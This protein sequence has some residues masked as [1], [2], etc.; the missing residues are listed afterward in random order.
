MLRMLLAC[1]LLFGVVPA[2]LLPSFRSRS[3]MERLFAMALFMG[4]LAVLVMHLLVRLRINDNVALVIL[5]LWAI[6]FK[7]WTRWRRSDIGFVLIKSVL[8]RWIEIFSRPSTARRFGITLSVVW[9]RKNLLRA[10]HVVM[11]LAVCLAAVVLRIGPIW[12]HPA[13]LSPEYYETLEQVKQLQASRTYA[14][15]SHLP[16]GMPMLISVLCSASQINPTLAV[17]YFGIIALVMLCASVYFSIFSAVRS[18]ADAAVGTAVFAC[19]YALLP[20]TPEHQIEADALTLALAFLL[21]SLSFLMRSIAGGTMMHLAASAA[22]LTAAASIDLFAGAAGAFL[23]VVIVLSSV[24]LLPAMPHLRGRRLF[25]HLLA[26]CAGAGAAAWAWQTTSADGELRTLLKLMFYD[27]HFYRYV[28]ADRLPDPVFLTA[29]AFLFIILIAA[30]FIPTRTSAPQMHLIGW[31]F[32]GIALLAMLPPFSLS[33]TDMIPEAEVVLV[34]CAAAAVGIGLFAS[35]VSGAIEQLLVAVRVSERRAA[36]VRSFFA[37]AMLSALVM[38][39]RGTPASLSITAEPDGFVKNLYII[40][41]T[42]IPYQWTIVAHRGIL[43]AG[44][45]RG[46]FLDYDYFTATYDPRTYVHGK[47]GAIPTAL[48]FIFIEKSPNATGISSELASLNRNAMRRAREWCET[49][50]QF[51]DDMTVFYSD[52]AVIIYQLRDPNI[53]SQRV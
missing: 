49:Y 40:D 36:A 26:A 28:Q 29:A 31:G 38:F 27:P 5:C 17:H 33:L 46:R 24:F 12:D 32:T 53:V 8:L 51:H 43:L 50:V 13:P 11:F 30:A 7:W 4:A 20:L 23:C 3:F 37:M 2:L 39:Y 15:A 47:P 6:G 35:L 44:M 16:K 10:A 1:A 34:L 25:L 18:N 48:V 45:N 22:G 19:A 9:E 21:P 52:E 41:R 14:D 42:F